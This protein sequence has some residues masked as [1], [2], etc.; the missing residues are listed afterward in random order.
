M[1]KISSISIV[2]PVYNDK[3][4]LSELYKRLK[5]VVDQLTDNYE[6]ILIDDGSRDNSWNEILLLQKQYPNIVGIRLA[7]NFGQA[8]AIT[9]GLNYAEKE[10]IVIMDSDLQDP[11]EFIENLY[12]ACVENGVDM[13][14]AKRISRK[15]SFF[16]VKISNFFNRFVQK[17]TSM[18]VPQGLGVFRIMKR[19]VYEKIANVP[20]ITGTTLSLI[21]W[22]GVNY[23]A[24]DLNR[25]AR[26]AG[27]SG[28]TI[29]KMLSLASTRIFSYSLWPL[30][31]A[32]GLGVCIAILSIFLGI[33]YLI[34]Y[35]TAGIG[36]SG[37]TTIVVLLLFLFSIL[38]IILG[39]IGEYIGK[40]YLESKKRPKYVVGELKK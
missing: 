28:Y 18:Y 36:I 19:D 23:V 22:S 1:K 15:D 2:I 7:R 37:W 39:I 10:Y 3:E 21:Y 24:V 20:E 29:F 8:N 9:A 38:F 31:L 34:R 32:T 14:I 4:V 26:F 11:P 33:F 6:I 35:F 27:N 13:A 16:K 12:N 30:R 5:P 40:I 25:E 17:T